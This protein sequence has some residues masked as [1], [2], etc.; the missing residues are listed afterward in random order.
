MR[1][2]HYRESLTMLQSVTPRHPLVKQ[3]AVELDRAA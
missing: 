1:L 3:L 2:E